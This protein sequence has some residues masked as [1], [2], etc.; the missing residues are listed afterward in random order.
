MQNSGSNESVFYL[1]NQGV[2]TGSDAYGTFNPYSQITRAETAAI[3]NRVLDTSKRKTFT[4]TDTPSVEGVYNLVSWK[5]EGIEY[6]TDGEWLEL[7]ADGTG[8]WFWGND[9]WSDEP[10]SLPLSAVYTLSGKSITIRVPSVYDEDSTEEC[11]DSGIVS[12]HF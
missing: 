2:L 9:S 1:Y 8:T 12:Q 4:L 11:F 6:G 7:R 10:V 3:L 5:S